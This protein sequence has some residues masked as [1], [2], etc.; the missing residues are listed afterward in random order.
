MFY[1]QWAQVAQRHC[2]ALAY[3]IGITDPAV[4]DTPCF[5]FPAGRNGAPSSCCCERKRVPLE[6]DE[7]QDL[8]V[9]R[10][11]IHDIILAKRVQTL[12]ND[13]AEIDPT[14]VYMTGH[15][16]GCLASLAMGAVH[17]DL[18]AAVCCHSGDSY[19]PF[20]PDYKPVPTWIG[21]GLR[22]R[23]F[24]R[25]RIER[26]MSE[27]GNAHNCSA[28]ATIEVGMEGDTETTYFDCAEDANVTL[29]TVVEG[30]HIPFLTIGVPPVA[31]DTTEMAYQFCSGFRK[32]AVPDGLRL[33]F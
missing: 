22:D 14:R 15:S 3:P 8:L 12:S 11:M 13:T 16:N 19:T 1:D 4:A 18:V 27:Y 2:F 32:E 23:S 17:S 29:L 21:L 10:N 25:Q 6:P 9:M 33:R 7:T 20:A 24:P 31:L 30:G 26:T 28:V 5:N